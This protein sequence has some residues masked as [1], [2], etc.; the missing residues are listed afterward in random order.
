MS[1]LDDRAATAVAEVRSHAERIAR[2]EE[3]LAS[4]MGDRRPRRR[5]V[6][7]MAGVAA[8]AVLVGVVWVAARP[9]GTDT[10]VPS[11][12]SEVPPTTVASTAAVTTVPV[13]TV[14]ATTTVPETDAAGLRGDGLGA[15]TFGQPA[16]DV[17]AA[18][19]AAWG[20]SQ[21]A[22]FTEVVR[23]PELVDPNNAAGFWAAWVYPVGQSACWGDASHVGLC[24][25]FGGPTDATVT[26]RGWLIADPV[27]GKLEFVDE[28]G[29]A[30]GA[31]LQQAGGSISHLV[32]ICYGHADAMLDNGIQVQVAS[33]VPPFDACANSTM[34]IDAVV[35]PQSVTISG[36]RAGET[37]QPKS[38]D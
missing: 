22:A 11:G 23:M 2:T 15:W 20:P 6:V 18:M 25:Y 5:P 24:A 17:L 30:V 9:D 31:T 38:G 37:V 28:Y 14:P 12:S 36:M 35:D 33:R 4:L 34:S 10:L 7:L 8:A 29:V 1:R 21:R 19:E 13:L 32:R 3:G 26:F 16:A 27:P